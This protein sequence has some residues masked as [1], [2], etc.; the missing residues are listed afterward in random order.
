MFR[1]RRTAGERFS[2]A[3]CLKIPHPHVAE[4]PE[5]R[6]RFRREA[7]LGA[8]FEQ[9]NIVPVVDYGVHADGTPF[10]VM[11]LVDAVGLDEAARRMRA[12]SET[13]PGPA[14]VFLAHEVLCALVHAHG[15]SQA[16]DDARPPV[17]HRDVRPSNILVGDEGLVKLT[18]FGTAAVARHAEARH[19]TAVRGTLG[20][21]APEQA[22]GESFDGRADLYAL[23]VVLYELLAGS[24]PFQT[25]DPAAPAHARQQRMLATRHA[26]LRAHRPDLPHELEGLVEALLQPSQDARPR[27]AALAVDSLRFSAEW[28]GAQAAFERWIGALFPETVRACAGSLRATTSRLPPAAQRSDAAG[29]DARGRDPARRSSPWRDRPVL[30]AVVVTALA[31]GT[32]LRAAWPRIPTGPAVPAVPPSPARASVLPMRAPTQPPTPPVLA[33][34]PPPAPPASVASA[35]PPPALPD[36]SVVRPPSAHPTAPHAAAT[37]STPRSTPPASPPPAETPAESVAG[38]GT[39]DVRAFP[40]GE[41]SVDGQARGSSPLRV[42]LAP[43][44]HTV[45]V[46]GGIDHRETVQ[47][48]AGHVV[49]VVVP[50][51]GAPITE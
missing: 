18:D 28:Q 41:V 25:Q 5:L 45:E 4:D 22:A 46:S 24:H 2:H 38:T 19:G 37:P 30:A 10:L 15:G 1:A 23:G 3:V 48:R 12:R 51:T 49:R 47:I 20:Y 17:V 13:L 32:L 27:T 50:P 9:R 11:P 16:L 36:A 43:G 8:R 34:S 35:S 29:P 14:A 31:T 42:D 7:V 26:P 21:M 6:S 40:W 39:L 44:P 33:P